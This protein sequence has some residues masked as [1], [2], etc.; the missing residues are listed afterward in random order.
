MNKAN[1]IQRIIRGGLAAGTTNL[2]IEGALVSQ[3]PTL[4]TKELL[5]ASAARICFRWNYK[6]N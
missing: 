4:G 6:R 2:A 5:I 1:R 3:N